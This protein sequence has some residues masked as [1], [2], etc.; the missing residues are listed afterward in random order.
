MLAIGREVTGRFNSSLDFNRIDLGDEIYGVNR[1]T[2]AINN[3]N[4]KYDVK[5]FRPVLAGRV[6]NVDWVFLYFGLPMAKWRALDIRPYD[7]FDH[8]FDSRTGKF[9][10]K[11][12][13]H[14]RQFVD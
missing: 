7:G 4:W 1:A 2:I 12:L 6:G 13:F 9:I 14:N 10:L 11:I 5:F 3:L 8:V